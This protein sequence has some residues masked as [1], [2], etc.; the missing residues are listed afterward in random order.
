LRTVPRHTP[1]RRASESGGDARELAVGLPITPWTEHGWNV[2]TASDVR[3]A[4]AYVEN[5][6]FA[7]AADMELR[8]AV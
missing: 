5:N 8:R 4:I 2:S 7:K 1:D 6:R 3:Q